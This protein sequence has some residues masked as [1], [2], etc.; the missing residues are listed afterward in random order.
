MH[1]VY[2]LSDKYATVTQQKAEA[3]R[4]NGLG[5]GHVRV[6]WTASPYCDHA[7]RAADSPASGRLRGLG[8]TRPWWGGRW[9]PLM[10]SVLATL[11][12]RVEVP[13]SAPPTGTV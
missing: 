3:E 11:R 10:R 12:A 1:P 5:G 6:T 4:S 8:V 13:M 9:C 7:K 2:R